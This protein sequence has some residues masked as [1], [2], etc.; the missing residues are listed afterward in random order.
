MKLIAFIPIA[1]IL[2]PCHVSAQ[3]S[4]GNQ[5][6]YIQYVGQST[7]SYEKKITHYSEKMLAR[8]SKEENKI[9]KRLKKIDPQKANE[10]FN[11]NFRSYSDNLKNKVYS[12]IPLSS[13]FDT[14]QLSLQFLH[15]KGW[16]KQYLDL[17]SRNQEALQGKLKVTEDIQAYIHNRRKQLQEQLSQYSQFS[18]NL[19]RLGKQAYYYKQ[20]LEEYKTIYENPSKIEKKAIS[21]LK[22]LPAYNEFVKNNSIIG[23]MFNLG[24]NYNTSRTLEGLQ[25]RTQVEEIVQTRLGSDPGARAAISQQ[26]QQVKDKISELKNKFPELNS[27]AEMPDFKPNPVKTKSFFKRL[28][29]GGNIQFQKSNSYYPTIGD[30]AGQVGYKFNKNGSIGLGISYKLGLGTGWNHIAFSHQGIGLR[31]YIDYKIK[32]SFYLTGGYEKNYFQHFS[33]FSELYQLKQWAESALLGVS[34]K[35]KINP[36]VKGNLQLL[37]DFLLKG[38][39]TTNHIK[40]RVGY[41][42]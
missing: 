41:N 40:V 24:E 2:F 38:N 33:N 6:K 15:K 8:F 29:Y 32:G 35:Y 17:A 27:Q 1:L 39:S 7:L 42:F 28:E 4:I 14:T 16:G 3:D 19:Q 18:K 37:Y 25:V 12:Q 10:L 34:K 5:I 9:Q 20:Q 22:K 30:I 36:K 21:E 11:N 23:N 31:S 13:H 26:M